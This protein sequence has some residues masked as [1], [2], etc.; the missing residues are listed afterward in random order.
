VTD[1]LLREAKATIA[2]GSKSFALASRLFDAPTRARA[3][4]LYAW[5][6]H[7]DD[8]TDEQELGMGFLGRA[9]T[10]HER[11]A[12]L[13]EETHAALNGGRPRGT[14]FAALRRVADETGLPERYAMDLITGFEMD[15]GEPFYRSTDHTLTYCYHVAGCVGVMMAI[16]MGVAPSDRRTLERACD[17]GL[18]FQLNN[19]A[20]DVVEDAARGRCY[21]P[22]QWLAEA[23]IEPG[24]EAKPWARE[25]LAH[26]VARL[27]NEAERYEASARVGAA[28]LSFRS[29]WAVLAAA[30]IYGA[31]GRKVRAAGAQAWDRRIGTGRIE[32]L[33]LL[34]RARQAAARREQACGPAAAPR[35]GLWTMPG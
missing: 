20:R 35:D 12:M 10:I 3:T 33:M 1:P 29:A 7:C 6:R 4:M 19:I 11:V 23:D 14:P 2:R 32:K 24:E 30:E 31:I 26:V 16:V 15:A 34:A 18:A 21:L 28:A 27:V 9:G 5:C 25:R 22:A 13:K 8:V 17:L